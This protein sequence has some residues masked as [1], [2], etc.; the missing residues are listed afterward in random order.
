MEASKYQKAVCKLGELL[1]GK[2]EWIQEHTEAFEQ[3]KNMF[4][5]DT[6]Q[7]YFD[8]QANTNSTWMGVRWYWQPLLPEEAWRT[9]VASRAVR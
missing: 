4:S 5:S 3:L 2:F 6:I 7:A 9:S 1:K 8:S